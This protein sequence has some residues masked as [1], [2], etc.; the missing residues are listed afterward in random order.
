M[1]FAQPSRILLTTTW[2][3]LMA[4]TA[5]SMAAGRAGSEAPAALG[6]I[7]V[8]V[9]LAVTVF[10]AFQVLNVFLN[11]RASPSGWRSGLTALLIAVC[12][13]VFLAY[14]VAGTLVPA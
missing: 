13:I 11:L 7:P 8:A 5:A 3:L 6:A 12:S 1:Q 2:G 14:L 9:I 10:K 4:L